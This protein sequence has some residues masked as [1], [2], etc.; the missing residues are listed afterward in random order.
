MIHTYIFD[1]TNHIKSHHLHIKCKMCLDVSILIF[2]CIVLHS[3]E[4]T[5]KSTGATESQ[6]KLLASPQIWFPTA[7][8]FLKHLSFQPK[9]LRPFL[10]F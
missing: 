7:T 10:V 9:P 2:M 5:V 3:W 8:T 6:G 1:I 4:T